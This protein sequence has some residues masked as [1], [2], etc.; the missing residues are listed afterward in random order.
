MAT[1]LVDYTNIYHRIMYSIW[2][3]CKRL[4]KMYRTMYIIVYINSYYLED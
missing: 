1:L 3:L 2:V 4:M